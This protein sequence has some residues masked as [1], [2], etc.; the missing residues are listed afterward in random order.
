MICIIFIA[1]V[2]LVKNAGTIRYM[3][4]KDQEQNYVENWGNYPYP[5]ACR[6]LKDSDA[7]IL[8]PA[9]KKSANR[10]KGFIS[11][12]KYVPSWDINTVQK[13][14]LDHVNS[15]F[16]RFHLIFTIGHE[17]VGFGSLAPMPK[18]REVQV[19]VWVTDGYEGQGIGS[20]IVT[21]LEWYA[22]NVFGFDVVYFQHDLGNMRSGNVAKRNGF[23]FSHVFNQKKTAWKELGY[24]VSYKK[25]KPS[26]TPPGF[27]DTGTFDNWDGITF[28][29]KS[30]I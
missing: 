4:D 30:L 18:S 26:N 17:V 19:A 21:V 28:P 23:K 24:W 7:P 11:W 6:V 12:A 15:D 13:F 1:H 9:M 29:W 16:P 25:S 27:I 2:R 22:F 5:L 20:W 8:Y 3:D 10:L 14:V